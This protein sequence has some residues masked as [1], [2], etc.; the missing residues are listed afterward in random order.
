M[1]RDGLVR[2]DTAAQT[3]AACA[4]PLCISYRQSRPSARRDPRGSRERQGRRLR[5][6]E[7]ENEKAVSAR[8][9]G[10]LQFAL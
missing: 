9:D 7:G 1:K 10:Y 6:G 8:V 5:Q 4:H 3:N 2:Q